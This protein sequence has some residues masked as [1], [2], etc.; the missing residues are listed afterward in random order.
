VEAILIFGHSDTDADLRHII[1]RSIWDDSLYIEA[2]GRRVLV[3]PFEPHLVTDT[4]SDL[5]VM[6][7][8]DF[9]GDELAEAGV[10]RAEIDLLVSGR[11]CKHLGVTSARVP[12]TFPVELADHLREAGIELLADRP[13]FASRRRSKTAHELDG[14]RRALRAGELG[15]GAAA[16]LLWRAVEDDGRLSANGERLTCE[17]V[18]KA[19]HAEVSPLAPVADEIIVA[20][21]AQSAIGHDPGSGEIAPGEPILIDFRPVD[22]GSKC[23][24]DITR[25]FVVGTP[26]EELVEYHEACCEALAFTLREA[27][28]GVDGRDLYDAVCD[29]F[30]ARGYGTDFATMPGPEA[31]FN[32]GLGHGI[33]LDLI[34]PPWLRGESWQLVAGDTLA[35]EPGLYRAGFG[36]CRIEENVYITAAGAELLTDFPTDLSPGAGAAQYDRRRASDRA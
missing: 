20:H 1:P 17:L 28:P 3:T 24:A 7:L 34:E 11:A 36:G 32:H 8:S 10:G 16:T 19:I 33:G 12:P 27:R 35:I 23:S 13:E 22:P 6:A 9:G 18:R 14:L 5:E 15:M 30:A 4:V 2:N 26:P 29:A 25:T 31:S 21:G